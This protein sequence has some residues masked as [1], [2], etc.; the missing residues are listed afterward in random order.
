M[1]KASLDY[2]VISQTKWDQGFSN[3]EFKINRYEIRK[4]DRNKHGGGL[5]EVAKQCLKHRIIF[6]SL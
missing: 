4:R 2:F 1:K 6:F 5:P 3:A